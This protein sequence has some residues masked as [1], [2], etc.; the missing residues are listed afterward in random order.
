MITFTPATKEH[1]HYLTFDQQ[2]DYL[3][4]LANEIG[5]TV[6]KQLI[7]NGWAVFFGTKRKAFVNFVNLYTFDTIRGDFRRRFVVD[8]PHNL[9]EMRAFFNGKHMP[10]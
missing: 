9:S 4:G 8:D 6:D 10:S 7:H 5:C 2:S 1:S 3:C